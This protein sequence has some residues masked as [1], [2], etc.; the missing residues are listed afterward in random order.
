M[1]TAT[2]PQDET[3]NDTEKLLYRM[4]WWAVDHLNLRFDDAL[5]EA[6]LAWAIAWDTYDRR[7]GA[8]FSTWLWH[9]VKGR[10]LS[11]KK[12]QARR[13]ELG[14]S[15]LSERLDRQPAREGRLDAL[16]REM[17]DDA[18]TV[19][20]LVFQDCCPGDLR[21]PAGYRGM[22]AAALREAGWTVGRVVES[23]D[24]IREVLA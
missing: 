17:G 2:L 3:F 20:H 7:R 16:L 5:S 11:L 4:C 1:T 21:D 12:R 22:V 8:S 14:L 24:E 6:G 15:L 13:S 9:Q 10:L 18:R 19:A 23:F